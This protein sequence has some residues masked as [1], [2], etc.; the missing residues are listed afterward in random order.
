MGRIHNSNDMNYGCNRG[1]NGVSD[2]DTN[3]VR[4]I[5]IN[6]VCNIDINLG[7]NIEYKINY[8]DIIIIFVNICYNEK[9]IY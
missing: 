3:C 4:N 2:I 9:E 5:G 8:K 6:C 7:L 1:I